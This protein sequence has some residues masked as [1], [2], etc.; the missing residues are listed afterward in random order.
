MVYFGQLRPGKGIEDFIESRDRIGAEVP[1]AAF[2]IIGAVIPKLQDF[3]AS[4][5]SEAAARGIAVVSDLESDGVAAALAAATVALL[6]FPGGASMRRG[7]LFAATACGVPIVT[8]TGPDTPAQLLPYLEP[9]Y[10]NDDLVGLTVRYLRDEAA[11]LNAH[12]R[13]VLLDS[14]VGWEQTADHYLSVFRELAG[15]GAVRGRRVAGVP[16]PSTETLS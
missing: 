14:Q 13:S 15:L 2:Q 4:V 12:R 5:R 11:R 3:A 8:T 7:S 6:P 1:E 10:S 16:R 9:A